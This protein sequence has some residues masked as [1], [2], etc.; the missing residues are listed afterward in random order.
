[1][2]QSGVALLTDAT[3]HRRVATAG[4]EVAQRKFCKDA[5]VPLYEQ[6]YREIVER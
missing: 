4:C 2:A 3:L 6:Y 5:I 1:M